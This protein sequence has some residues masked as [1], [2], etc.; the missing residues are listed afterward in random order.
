ME[1]VY[2]DGDVAL[3]RATSFD[4]DG[5]VYAVSWNGSVYIKKL[6]REEDGFRMVSINKAKNPERFIPYED[7]P[8]IVGKVVGHFTPVTKVD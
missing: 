4:Y 2:P 6:Y 3:I 8:I 1:P 7:E 5:A